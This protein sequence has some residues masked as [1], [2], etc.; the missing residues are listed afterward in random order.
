MLGLTNEFDPEVKEKV[1]E[2]FSILNQFLTASK[3]VAGN[4]L[5]IADFSIV[6]ALAA[7][8][9]RLYSFYTISSNLTS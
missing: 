5:S 6:G 1:F 3:W 9:V 2:A 7:Y 4:E 8:F